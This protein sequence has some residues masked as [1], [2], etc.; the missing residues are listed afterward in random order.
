[1]HFNE[2]SILVRGEL[3]KLAEVSRKTSSV[4]ELINEIEREGSYKGIESFFKIEERLLNHLIRLEKEEAKQALRTLVELI[5]LHAT[6]KRLEN[7]KYYLVTVSSLVTR[8]LE[9]RLLTPR[10]AFAFNLTCFKLIDSKLEVG[11]TSEMADELVEFF[12]FALEEKKHPSLSHDTVNKVILYIDD[13]VESPLTVEDIAKKFDVS[14][15]HLSRIFR[16]HTGVTLVEYINIRKVEESQYYLRFSDKKIS[17]ISDQFNFCNQ[18]YFT[19]IFKKYTK[20]TP[21]RFRSSL[22]GSY[23]R[24]SL[25]GDEDLLKGELDSR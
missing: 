13:E 1:M 14:T 18:S 11:N 12:I 8:H 7:V 6:S 5:S 15:S 21:R 24:F 25:P 9:G 23:F 20:E 17:D 3:V 16:V 10:K 22:T 4:K 2:N 19:R